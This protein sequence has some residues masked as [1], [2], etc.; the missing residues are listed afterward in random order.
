MESLSLKVIQSGIWSL[1]SN[2]IIRGLGVIKIIILA[3]L[4]S[5]LDF[6]ILGLAML[7]IN[8]LNVFSETG[9]EP[10]LIQRVKIGRA[11]L[12]TAWTMA[13]MRGV[14][15][16]VILFLSAGWLSAYFDNF[17]LEPV[18]KIMAVTF[19]IG[20]CTNIGI[21]FFQKDLE[22]KKKAILESIADI[23]GTVIAI[24]LALWLRN[25]WA[26]VIGSIVWVTVKCVGSY[27]LSSYRPRLQWNWNIALGLLNFGK[28]IFW[29]NLIAFIITN[30]DDALVG[31]LLDLNMLGFYVMAYSISS[32]PVTS[33]SAELSRIFFPA[34]AKIQ[35][36]HK[37]IAE[38]FGQTFE[39]VMLMLLPL[40]SLMITQAP[41]FTAVFLGEK[42]LF[43]VPALQV[44]CF[45][46]LFRCISGLFYPLHLAINRPDI[47]TKI[48][49]LDLV[50]FL[51]LIYPLTLNWGIL[52]T[53]FAMALVYLINMVM[54]IASTVRVIPLQWNKLGTSLL[55]PCFI[56]LMVVMTDI[57]LRSLKLP[58]GEMAKNIFIMGLCLTVVV[59]LTVI[60][61]RQLLVKILGAL[62]TSS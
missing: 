57:G 36:D 47:Q 62:K 38:A 48:K 50:T 22:F 11:E 46:G 44:L 17:T 41:N 37:R 31:K 55:T 34:Y 52:G 19:L 59:V 54:N 30:V 42:W 14:L 35:N 27:R 18:L 60:F 29:I 1:G 4:L 58:V 51:I 32:I 12:N 20:G 39:T 23:A 45:F 8:A 3:R 16:F 6:G 21:V 43:M 53:S 61:R 25:V 49:S 5:P 33:L 15:L 56:S 28:H 2:W 26:L 10:A 24:L 7:S 40:T 13:I 9:I